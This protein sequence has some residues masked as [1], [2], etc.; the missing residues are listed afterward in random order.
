MFFFF[1]V[2]FCCVVVWLCFLFC[3]EQD[4]PKFGFTE[5]SNTMSPSLVE[6]LQTDWDAHVLNDMRTDRMM[7]FYNSACNCHSLLSKSATVD[8]PQQEKYAQIM[9]ERGLTFYSHLVDNNVASVD[10]HRAMNALRLEKK[11]FD[12]GGGGTGL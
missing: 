7:Y 2:F 1:F 5:H 9:F 6:L 3:Q 4:M 8:M 11:K 10:Q 12:G